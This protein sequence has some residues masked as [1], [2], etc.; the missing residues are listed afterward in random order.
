MTSGAGQKYA[1]GS[2]PA[3]PTAHLLLLETLKLCTNL[4]SYRK[5]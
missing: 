3:K 5:N 2:T 4:N 1:F